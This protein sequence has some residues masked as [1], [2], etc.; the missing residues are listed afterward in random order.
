MLVD[1]RRLY[2]ATPCLLLVSS[3]AHLS[4]CIH[5]QH[6]TSRSNRT[7]TANI[8]MVMSSARFRQRR[9]SERRGQKGAWWM[10]GRLAAAP[11]P[12]QWARTVAC[13]RMSACMLCSMAA[14][15]RRTRKP[16]TSACSFT[17]ALSARS[18]FFACTNT[19]HDYSIEAE[20]G[21]EHPLLTRKPLNAVWILIA[22]LMRRGREGAAGSGSDGGAR[23]G[24]RRRTEGVTTVA[25]RSCSTH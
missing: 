2:A 8:Y 1:S 16:R 10:C 20:L 18:T 13:A 19:W 5:R 17:S 9:T 23:R 7:S 12:V 21:H 24:Q 15:C 3:V 6:T 25:C 11:A 14:A 4:C 22:A